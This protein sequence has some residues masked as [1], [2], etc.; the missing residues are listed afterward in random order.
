[1]IAILPL[2]ER[3]IKKL[4]LELHSLIAQ[5]DPKDYPQIY[6]FLAET[7]YHYDIDK[8]KLDSFSKETDVLLNIL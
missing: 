4:K 7:I 3:S 5:K 6:T 2:K 1:M 8:H